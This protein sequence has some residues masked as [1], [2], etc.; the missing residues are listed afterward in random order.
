MASLAKMQRLSWLVLAVLI[1]GSTLVV[2][3]AF[4]LAVLVGGL[5]SIASFFVSIRDIMGL[6]DNIT[7]TPIPDQR[8]ARAQQGQKGYLLRFWLRLLL[9]GV[10]LAVLIKWR[11]V[12]IFG[13]ILGLSTVV[14]SVTL[15]AMGEAGR[16][17]LRGR[18]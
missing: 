6:V 11:L 12:D 2:S 14:V 8:Q 7:S 13:M 5:L 4:G 15:I 18:R 17:L 10:V 16:Y 1:A 3:P 9:L